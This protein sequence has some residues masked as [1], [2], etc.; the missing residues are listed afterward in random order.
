VI[1]PLLALLL[2]FAP[3]AAGCADDHAT[4]RPPIDAAT[5]DGSQLPE[6]GTDAASDG[7]LDGAEVDSGLVLPAITRPLWLG[8]FKVSGRY[9]DYTI[10]ATRDAGNCACVFANQGDFDITTQDPIALTSKAAA[11]LDSLGAG[12][13]IAGGPSEISAAVPYWSQVVSLYVTGE[14]TGASP[15]DPAPCEQQ[16]AVA[17]AHVQSLG[18]PNRPVLCYFD[19]DI[20]VD[21]EGIWHDPVGVDWIG[22]N[23]YLGPTAPPTTEEAIAQLRDRIRNQLARLPANRAVILMAQAYDRNGAWTDIPMLEQLQPIYLEEAQHDSRIKGIWW[24]SYSRPGGTLT[25]P[26]LRPWHEAVFRANVMGRP[27]IESPP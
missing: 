3:V 4:Q 22:I 7:G 23:A 2:L 19:T 11:D 16:A 18:I 20:S 27:P 1:R 9:G 25:H 13:V 15:L 10:E 5:D 17:R 24:F 6:A 26:S 12:I 8:Y 14:A 21:P